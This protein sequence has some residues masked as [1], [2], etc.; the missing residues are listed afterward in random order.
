MDVTYF[1]GTHAPYRPAGDRDDVRSGRTGGRGRGT[2]GRVE[3]Q[4]PGPRS[5][6]DAALY[7][8]D[9]VTAK[10]LKDTFAARTQRSGRKDR[11]A[12]ELVACVA[13][14]Y[15]RECE[16]GPFTLSTLVGYLGRLGATRQA[17]HEFERYRKGVP[18][19]SEVLASALFFAAGTGRDMQMI[20]QAFRYAHDSGLGVSIEAWNAVLRGVT[21]RAIGKIDG[22]DV[23]GRAS[24]E[25]QLVDA[26]VQR[27][28]AQNV[29]PNIMTY[30]VLLPLHTPATAEKVF[31]H[32]T[33]SDGG[34]T[35][36]AAATPP[37][38]SGFP[39]TP[40]PL[41]PNV[42][43]YQ[44]LYLCC[45]RAGDEGKAREW[46]KRM[47]KEGYPMQ[48]RPVA[49]ASMLLHRRR[50][51]LDA[52]FRLLEDLVEGAEDLDPDCSED[53][54]RLEQR[55]ANGYTLNGTV[56]AHFVRMC[57]AACTRPADRADRL[58][59]YALNAARAGQAPVL[60]SGRAA[61][62]FLEHFAHV[63]SDAAAAEADEL[64]GYLVARGIRTPTVRT[65]PADAATAAPP[66][67]R[68]GRAADGA[69]S[70]GRGPTDAEAV[71]YTDV[72]HRFVYEEYV[73]GVDESD[74]LHSAAELQRLRQR[75]STA[76][77]RPTLTTDGAVE[78]MMT[79]LR[80]GHIGGLSSTFGRVAKVASTAGSPRMLWDAALRLAGRVLEEDVACPAL[81]L[82]QQGVAMLVVCVA[83]VRSSYMRVGGQLVPAE[84][85]SRLTGG[86]LRR[87]E[88]ASRLVVAATAEF[89]RCPRHRYTMPMKPL[90]DACVA[91]QADLRLSAPKKGSDK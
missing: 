17:W 65:D 88:L 38:S 77:G 29:E 57:T 82:S 39:S 37:A 81:G 63:G 76:A 27:M 51:D 14:L 90:V 20:E 56:L 35:A 62:P 45:C 22:V 5:H 78:H 61:R 4:D 54:A 75:P 47:E 85:V 33:L 87:E 89:L 1:K 25:L 43:T 80:E 42:H 12:I 86:S 26:F 46:L 15:R 49:T 23:P 68:G 66:L 67:V 7:W 60:A 13:D 18:V 55:E 34:E 36:A 2:T 53:K 70:S 3:V 71:P 50:G 79:E 41:Q 28:I 40:Q 9:G 19:G 48:C 8:Q 32:I 72:P 64:G 73:Q 83:V 24:Q 74:M 11:V 31:E 52:G 58:V 21:L 91:A 44:A 10:Y 59:R 6:P 30:N 16:V 84:M 69:L